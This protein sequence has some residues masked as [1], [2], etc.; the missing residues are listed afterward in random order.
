MGE[1]RHPPAVFEL[2]DVATAGIAGNVFGLWA[3]SSVPSLEGV[4]F[5]A[6]SPALTAAPLW[7]A[8]FPADLDLAAAQMAS[9]E[10][11][12]QASQNGLVAAANRLEAF[13]EA[14]SA[15]LA[16]EASSAEVATSQPEAELLALLR[17]IREG[18]PAVRFGLAEQLV[19]GW[20]QT[21]QRFQAFVDRLLQSIA[22][23]AWVETHIQGQLLGRT[24]VRWIGDV[25][26]VWLRALDAA[27]ATVHHRTLAL[28]LASRDTL[29][30]T[31]V[32]AVR[33]AAK[34]A[35]LLA[36]PGGTILALPAVW[37]FIN[38]VLAEVRKYQERAKAVGNG[39]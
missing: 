14:Q 38:Q 33:S 29:I 19:E 16:F 12:L 8:H 23:Y 27:Q 20:E 22:H 25:D 13:V 37:N 5:D 1:G 21:A 10:A 7:R 2:L 9:A 24:R 39:D 4:V 18:R 34:V 17:E 6:A 35:V 28:A 3:T 36:V 31:L 11:T 32:L 26:T 15:G 30:R